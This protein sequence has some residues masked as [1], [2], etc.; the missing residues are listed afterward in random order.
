[1]VLML[2]WSISYD[3]DDIPDCDWVVVID[4]IVNGAAVNVFCLNDFGDGDLDG[5]SDDSGGGH[6]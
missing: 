2:W 3:N 4:G 1:M 6:A 5:Y